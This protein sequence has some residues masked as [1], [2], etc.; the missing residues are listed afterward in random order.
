MLSVPTT[1]KAASSDLRIMA[2]LIADL[3]ASGEVSDTV[4]C[5]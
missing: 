3:A 1:A 5:S 4:T 2:L